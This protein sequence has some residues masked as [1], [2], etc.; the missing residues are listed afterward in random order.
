MPRTIITKGDI[1]K[2]AAR[3]AEIPDESEA[4]IPIG[5]ATVRPSS[6]RRSLKSRA[7]LTQDTYRDKLL[8]YI[9]AEVVALYLAL[10]LIWR[11]NSGAEEWL[12]W[13]ILIFG[14][15]A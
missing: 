3:A 14:F 15:V 9:P 11:S 13:L 12:R 7:E 10:D 8:K 5:A 2:A 1:E 4:A 6:S